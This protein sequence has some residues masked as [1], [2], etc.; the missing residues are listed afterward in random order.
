MGNIFFKDLIVWQKA[1]DLVKEVYSLTKQLPNEE[2][3]DL[4][5]QIRRAVISVP[6]N[7]AE[8]NSRNT[9]KEYI[10]FLGIAR[11]SISEVWTQLIICNELNYFTDK[12]IQKAVLLCEEI[13]KMLNA[14]ITKLSQ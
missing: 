9:K 1:I 12:Q 3:F 11:G 5:S 8:G 10:N 6:S 14:M 7:I 4:S 13:S 2:K